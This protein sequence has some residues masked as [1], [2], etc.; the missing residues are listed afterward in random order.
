LKLSRPE[1]LSLEIKFD[2]FQM[3][4]PMVLLAL[5]FSVPSSKASFMTPGYLDPNAG[6][7]P[8]EKAMD[9]FDMTKVKKYIF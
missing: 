8:L 2:F 7:C 4:W 1:V 6:S 3:L 9:G 5:A